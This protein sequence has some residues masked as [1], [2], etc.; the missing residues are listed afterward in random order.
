MAVRLEPADGGSVWLPSVSNVTH[1]QC[2][3]VRWIGVCHQTVD[4]LSCQSQRIQFVQQTIS[5][6]NDA[7]RAHTSNLKIQY[8]NHQS[9]VRWERGTKWIPIENITYPATHARLTGRLP[10]ATLPRLQ[11]LDLVIDLVD[12]LVVRFQLEQMH[13][14]VARPLNVCQNQWIQIHGRLISVQ[15][16]NV[17]N[18]SA[19]F[20]S[21]ICAKRR[22]KQQKEKRELIL[23][24]TKN[25]VDD[26][27][28]REKN[29][30]KSF[31]FRFWPT[32]FAI[33]PNTFTKQKLHR[34]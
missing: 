4:L 12:H 13:F 24:S 29:V 5:G 31:R 26:K 32:A 7:A 27:I 8:R 30:N 21:I 14:E 34:L 11:M 18:F 3:D 25:T 10:W 16:Q 22:I 17:V 1:T 23:I 20:P 9:T 15:W 2:S 33:L 28:S 19:L 6:G